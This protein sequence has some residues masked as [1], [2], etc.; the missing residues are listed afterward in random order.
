MAAALA[1][2]ASLVAPS[3][4]ASAQVF[5]PPSTS[6][7]VESA[8]YTGF[9]NG[10]LPVQHVTPGLLFDRFI[11]IW[12]ENTDFAVANSTAEFRSLADRG[13]LMTRYY[14][15][16]H[17]SQPNY[18]AAL[19][20]SF[21]GMADDAYYNIPANVSTM[22]D[23]LEQANIS[24]ASYQEHMPTDGYNEATYTSNNYIDPSAADY[25][26][27]WRKH[28]PT[29]IYDSVSN[30][31][32]RAALHRNF[33]DFAVD[34]NAS[35][36]PQW[37]FVTPNIVND[38]HD[39]TIDFAA[40]FLNYW[41]EP[42]LADPR[43]N[44]N[45]TLIL[46][47]FDENENY[48]IN[49]QIFSVLLGGALPEELRGTVDTTYYTHYSSMSSI[50]ANWG[51][52]SLGRNDTNEMMANVWSFIADAVGYNNTFV[53]DADIPLTNIT[54][55][56]P[57]PLNS[58]SSFVTPWPAPNTSAVGAGGGPVFVSDD[59]EECE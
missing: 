42:L 32:S 45:R 26:Y 10:S 31:S 57:G 33:N 44:D 50:Q 19:G 24:W 14:A 13:V 2:V 6:P 51:L 46:I 39:T 55:T 18:V 27:Y 9:S 16:T 56:I 23:L 40:D 29:I 48:G 30:I 53:A 25:T 52:G 21:W 11:Q 47:T 12:F 58:N 35:A 34:V 1:V 8:N 37:V 38:A 22:V 43:F 3:F 49:N 4:A 15:L 36:I 20:G 17:P 5:S 59:S 54:G 7:Y 41:L 28:N